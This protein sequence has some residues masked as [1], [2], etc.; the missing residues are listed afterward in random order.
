MGKNGEGRTVRKQRKRAA[1]S[2]ELNHSLA[3]IAKGAGI[4]FF[5]MMIGKAIKEKIV[6]A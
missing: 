1:E 4:V 5:G 6:I 3:K 2:E